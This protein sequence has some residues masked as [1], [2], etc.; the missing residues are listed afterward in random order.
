MIS[1]A[2]KIGRELD[3]TTLEEATVG[4]TAA[5]QRIQRIQSEIQS[6][7][8]LTLGAAKKGNQITGLIAD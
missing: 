5:Q 7:Q 2:A 3:I 1:Q 4:D 8:G 6:K